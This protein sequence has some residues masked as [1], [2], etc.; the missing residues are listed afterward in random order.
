MGTPIERNPSG[1][2]PVCTGPLSVVCRLIEITSNLGCLSLAP[3]PW[4]E[5]GA[6]ENL[7]HAVPSHSSRNHIQKGSRSRQAKIRATVKFHSGSYANTVT[8]RSPA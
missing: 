8:H 4:A 2:G 6:A 7:S 1:D 3:A 5:A